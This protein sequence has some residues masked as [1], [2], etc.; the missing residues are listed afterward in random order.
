[1]RPATLIICVLSTPLLSTAVGAAIR[2]SPANFGGHLGG[3][4]G[5]IPASFHPG[6]ENHGF[7]HGWG[8]FG[9]G[10]GH[11]HGWGW[12]GGGWH[13]GGGPGWGGGG[14]GGPSCSP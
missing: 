3:P 14:G 7:G 12:G 6:D 1:M 2:P 9:G 10:W 11:N 4:P 8:H 13:H 5:F